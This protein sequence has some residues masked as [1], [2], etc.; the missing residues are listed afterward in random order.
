[1][2]DASWKKIRRLVVLAVLSGAAHS[3]WAAREISC[4]PGGLDTVEGIK[5]WSQLQQHYHRF[6]RGRCDDGA[7]AEG[8]SDVV[9]KL[10]LK[11]SGVAKLPFLVKSDP[12]FRAFILHH[13]DE[14][15]QQGNPEIAAAH[16]RK[17]CPKSAVKLCRD[18][19]K[20]VDALHE[21]VPDAPESGS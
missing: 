5:S 6:G 18:I 2:K 19:V 10:L 11:W 4:P 9:E 8:Y 13:I 12:E 16:A 20:A 14:L 17:K 7:L 15:W 3:G 21:P 1:M